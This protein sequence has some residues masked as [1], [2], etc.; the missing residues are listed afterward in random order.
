MKISFEE[1]I[2]TTIN[3]CD[4]K[5]IR[6][7]IDVKNLKTQS[8]LVSIKAITF[9]SNSKLP[10][11]FKQ[12]ANVQMF[13]CPVSQSSTS[14]NESAF[15]KS[16]ERSLLAAVSKVENKLLLNLCF[17]QRV[18]THSFAHDERQEVVEEWGEA[19]SRH[20]RGHQGNSLTSKLLEHCIILRLKQ[21]ARQQKAH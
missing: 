14:K 1:K 2:N 9:S 10:L 17:C 21:T 4:K 7:F 18:Q 3:L 13:N 16:S 19:V 11:V 6:S 20:R 15:S 12:L 8:I 5:P